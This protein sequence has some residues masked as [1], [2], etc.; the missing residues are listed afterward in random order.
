MFLEGVNIRPQ[1]VHLVFTHD[2]RPCGEVCYSVVSIAASLVHCH[3]HPHPPPSQCFVQLRS[4]DDK[5]LAL[6][7]HRRRI[8]HRYVEVTETCAQELAIVMQG[9]SRV[10][11]RG[12]AF[13]PILFF[14]TAWPP[15]W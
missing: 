9:A 11:K 13:Y 7:K 2:N 10:C 8:G 6:S 12:M 3:M 14:Y 15:F 1:G 5:D 4:Q